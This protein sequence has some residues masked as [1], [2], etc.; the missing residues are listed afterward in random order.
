ME[1][2]FARGMTALHIGLFAVLI[3]AYRYLGRLITITR[4][5]LDSCPVLSGSRALRTCSCSVLF[6][7]NARLGRTL[8]LGVGSSDR[9]EALN[10]VLAASR[11][12]R[13]PSSFAP[14]TTHVLF[15]CIDGG[16]RDLPALLHSDCDRWQ[17]Q[18]P[19]RV[20]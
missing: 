11:Y 18:T 9:A 7:L 5:H 2:Y 1:Y 15:Q 14:T 3:V 19:T 13:Q 16:D 6:P 12:H 8:I 17:C 20:H 10:L 4:H